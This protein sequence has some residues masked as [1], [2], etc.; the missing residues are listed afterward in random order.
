MWISTVA[1]T[2]WNGGRRSPKPPQ[3]RPDLS[4]TAASEECIDCAPEELVGVWRRV[5]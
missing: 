2:R 3:A 1:T 4:A 5:D